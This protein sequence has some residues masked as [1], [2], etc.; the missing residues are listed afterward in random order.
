MRRSVVRIRE[1]RI[2]LGHNFVERVE[3]AL[4]YFFLPLK[5]QLRQFEIVLQLLVSRNA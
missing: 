2:S 5:Q 1:E 3:L 4:C